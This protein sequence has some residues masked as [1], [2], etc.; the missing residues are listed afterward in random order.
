MSLPDD[1]W[2]AI[3]ADLVNA[4]WTLEDVPRR[5]SWSALYAF[6]LHSPATSALSRVRSPEQASWV[7]GTGLATLLAAIGYRLDTANWQ[8]S[9][10]GQ[11]NRRRPQPWETPWNK[12]KNRRT[13]GAGPIP[14]SDWEAFWDGGK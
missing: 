11:K 3:E 4:G 8:R 5:L 9:K 1:Q 7:D 6:V 2:L 14:A 10:D 12:S 13:I